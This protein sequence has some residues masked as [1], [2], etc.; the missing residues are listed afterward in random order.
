MPTL[1][2]IL[3][4]FNFKQI[5]PFPLYVSTIDYK[6]Y[7][8]INNDRKLPIT[9]SSLNIQY[10]YDRC[11]FHEIIHFR[12]NTTIISGIFLFEQSVNKCCKFLFFRFYTRKQETGRK[13]AL[14]GLLHQVGYEMRLKYLRYLIYFNDTL[15]KITVK[16][17]EINNF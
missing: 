16:E 8:S 15:Y 1:I 7:I 14:D 9:A 6:Y 5:L 17:N 12:I 2:T 10:L 11:K 3:R 4:Y 13:I